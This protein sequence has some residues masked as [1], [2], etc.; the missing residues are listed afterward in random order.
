MTFHRSHRS[1]RNN[2][3]GR[4]FLSSISSPPSSLAVFQKGFLRYSLKNSLIM[5]PWKPL[6][7][8][9]P[10]ATEIYPFQNLNNNMLIWRKEIE[11]KPR[12]KRFLCPHF[13]LAKSMRKRIFSCICVRKKKNIKRTLSF[14]IFP[15][16]SCSP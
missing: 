10:T 3:G 14:K 15:S 12:R 2:V 16:F 11:V 9:S 8:Y 1:Q 6:T 7:K 4:Y 5:I 13:C